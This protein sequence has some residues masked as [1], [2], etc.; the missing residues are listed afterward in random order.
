MTMIRLR[1]TTVLLD[2]VGRVVRA[3]RSL[4]SRT[5]SYRARRGTSIRHEGATERFGIEL[6]ALREV[7]VSPELVSDIETELRWGLLWH[8]F[9]RSMQAEIDRVFAPYLPVPECRD[10]GDVR[11][12]LGLPEPALP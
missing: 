10:F 11:E 6:R 5:G 2:L 12:L 4:V 9:E 7:Q 3:V 1:V 8:E